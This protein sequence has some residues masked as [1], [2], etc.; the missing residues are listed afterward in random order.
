M[1]GSATTVRQEL[2]QTY[3]TIEEAKADIS[4]L[5]ALQYLIDKGALPAE[6]QQTMYTTFLASAFRSIRF[7]L[8][9]AH[10]RGIAIQLNTLLDA[11][12]FVVAPD[13]TFS[14]DASKIRGAVANLT[15]DIMTLQAEGSLQKA[16]TSDRPLRRRPAGSPEGP[17]SSDRC[18]GG[19][20]PTICHRRRARA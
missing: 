2:K 12:A 20:R 5:W 10:G 6:M 18:S 8:N 7:G 4:G 19:H 11:G 3:S 1:A 14:V 13:G 15:R 17:R 16:Q 9:E